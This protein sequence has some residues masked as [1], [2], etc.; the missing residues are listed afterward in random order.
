MSEEQKKQIENVAAKMNR[1]T[2]EQR[3]KVLI[4]M[5]GVEAGAASEK[6]EA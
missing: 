5:Y 4:F 1:M 2:P 6:K 3:E